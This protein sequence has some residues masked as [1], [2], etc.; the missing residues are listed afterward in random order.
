MEWCEQVASKPLITGRSIALLIAAC[1]MFLGI[2]ASPAGASSVDLLTQAN[3]VIDG[4]PDS[5]NFNAYSVASA[6][7]VNGDGVPT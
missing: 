1:V 5:S 2:V 7:D 4:A 3:L 6:G